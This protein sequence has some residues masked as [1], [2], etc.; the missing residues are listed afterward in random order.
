MCNA[1]RII[2]CTV[3]INVSK[4]KKKKKKEEI[5]YTHKQRKQFA[6][7]VCKAIDS[8]LHL[9]QTE[10]KEYYYTHNNVILTCYM[11]LSHDYYA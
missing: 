3:H 11:N 9:Q 8:T 1:I 7:K 6:S 2:I 10:K 4:V 5:I